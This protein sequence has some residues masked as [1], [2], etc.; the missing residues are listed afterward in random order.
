MKIALIEDEPECFETFSTLLEDHSH[1]VK[2]FIEADEVIEHINE[3][4]KSDLVILDL[5]IQL[6]T[7][8]DPNEGPETGIAIY[9]RL[10]K[11]VR[12][13][14]NCSFDSVIKI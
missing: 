2:T 12:E 11:I 9:K 7:V 14:E 6:G 1:E 8:I 3:I 4:V 5:M 10:R 13:I